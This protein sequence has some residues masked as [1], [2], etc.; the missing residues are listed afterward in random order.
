M[1]NFKFTRCILAAAL[2]LAVPMMV[3]A[4]GGATGVGTKVLSIGPRAVYVTPKDADE[5]TWSGGAQAR[6]HISPSLALEGSIDYR[7]NTYF[8]ITTIKTYPVQATILAYLM[9][10]VFVSPYLLAGA[11]LYY[12]EV[13]GPL[14]FTNTYSRFGVHAGAGLEIM[15]NQSLSLDGSYRYVWLE[16]VTSKDQNAID[17]TYEDS[18]SMITVA[19]NFLF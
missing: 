1:K 7:S 8:H 16:S 6:L 17:K 14:N 12:T 11:G 15:I 2:L 5:G 19:L 10:G 3:F 9:P 4:D 13:D 18:G